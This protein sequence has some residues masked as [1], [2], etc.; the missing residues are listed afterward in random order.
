[1]RDVMDTGKTGPGERGRLA[2]RTRGELGWPFCGDEYPPLKGSPTGQRITRKPLRED[3]PITRGDG[4]TL[5][6]PNYT[7][8]LVDML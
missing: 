7:R 1:M 2:P 5:R 4:R 6:F 8:L 3:R